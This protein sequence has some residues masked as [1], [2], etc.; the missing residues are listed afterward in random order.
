[1]QAS[2]ASA[3]SL[4]TVLID[5]S[6]TRLMERIELPSQSMERIWMRVARGSLLA[7]C[8]LLVNFYA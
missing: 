1:M 2:P 8:P 4:A 7:I 3:S 6:A 5:T